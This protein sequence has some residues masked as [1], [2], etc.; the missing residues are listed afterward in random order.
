[1][2]KRRQKL[3]VELEE[4]HPMYE[5]GYIYGYHFILDIED[6]AV[7]AYND[8]A[9]AFLV[10]KVSKMEEIT[11]KF[12]PERYKRTKFICIF[13]LDSII[14]NG[15]PTIADSSVVNNLFQLRWALNRAGAYITIRES[16]KSSGYAVVPYLDS[17]EVKHIIEYTNEKN[18]KIVCESD[19]TYA[20]ELGA[21]SSQIFKWYRSS[22]KDY[23]SNKVLSQRR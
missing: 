8:E 5:I 18:G 22:N 13:S 7:E 10:E 9:F 1:M 12:N 14:S 3:Y 2:S 20:K 4:V 11:R 17:K 23:C 16:A 19:N 21:I 15:R 6:G